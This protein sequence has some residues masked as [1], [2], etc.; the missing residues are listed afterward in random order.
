MA[1]LAQL[2]RAL[3]NAD[4]AGDAAAAQQLAQAI[5]AQRTE[6]PK[7]STNPTDDMSA[8]DRLR[9]GAGRG[10]ASAGRAISGALGATPLGSLNRA[11]HQAIPGMPGRL[12][13]P[14][15]AEAE[16]TEAARL[17]AP[18]MSTRAGKVGNVIGLG[19][20]AAPTALIPGANTALGAM[21]IGGGTGGLTTE[22]GLQERAQ[23]A[24]AG[25]LGGLAGK[26]IGDGLGA[27]ARWVADRFAN[28]AAAANAAAAPRMAAAQAGAREGYVVPPA[29][30]QP[31]MATELLSGLSGKIKTAQTASQRNQGVTND[32]AARAL[33][34]PKGQQITPDVL[35]AL[36][37]TAG[38][39]G[40]APIRAAGDVTAD[41]TY[42]KALDAIAGQYQGAARSFPGAA[43]NPVLEMVDG[44]RQQKFDAGDALDMVKVLRETADK[45]YRGG[46][47]GLGKAS[48]AAAGAIEEQLER[49]L[50]AAG[51]KQALAAFKEARA[52]IA[53]T[54]T[55]QKGLNAETGDVSAAALA[56][57]LQKGKPLSGDLRTAAA[58]AAAFPKATQ[59]LKEAPK[60]WSPLDAFAGIGGLG[61]GSPGLLAA[62]AARPAARSLLL[63]GPMQRAALQQGG[64]GLLTQM[65]AAVL[66]NQLIRR[67]APGLLGALAPLT[68]E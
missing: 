32:L 27:G 41:A 49:H 15:E 60:A 45:A 39:Q 48:K 61:M 47:T 53:K 43:K 4:A 23:G 29:D 37:T 42:G 63:S 52:Q 66:E 14:E 5:R 46:D 18:L 30:L 19:A 68:I 26:Y 65:P 40:Y 67:G 13:T 56:R 20:V 35:Q 22:G 11:V 62:A 21:L 57:E 10:M 59:S 6:A 38:T 9:A 55:V 12:P 64:P 17:E 36:R 50:T 34:L 33:G 7:E 44:L 58:F 31:G 2:E 54:Y 16:R 1:D 28:R 8:L 51:N 24:G 3:R 25:A